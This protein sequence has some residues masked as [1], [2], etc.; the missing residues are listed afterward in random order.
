MKSMLTCFSFFF[1]KSTVE[2]LVC[3][4]I[5]LEAMLLVSHGIDLL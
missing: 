5:L 1:R 2:D 4:T 3:G